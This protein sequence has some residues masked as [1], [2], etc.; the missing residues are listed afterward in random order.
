MNIAQNLW[1]LLILPILA[2]L[3]TL[4]PS[5]YMSLPKKQITLGLSLLASGVSLIITLFN[6]N[7]LMNNPGEF[8]ETNIM[9]LDAS[10]F[11]IHIGALLDNV[12]VFMLT[13]LYLITIPVQ[14]FSFKYMEQPAEGNETAFSRY[15]ILLNLFI[16][17]MAGLILSTNL[18]QTYIFWELVGLFSYLL[19]GFYYK[20]PEAEQAARKTFLINKIG[21]FALFAA[22][23]G[24]TCFLVQDAETVLYPLLSLN[25]V[26][27]WGLMAYVQLG[28]YMYAALCILIIIAGFT[29][30]AQVPF[31][32]W[33]ADAMEGPAPV[34][35]LIHGAT[36]VSAGAYLLIRLYPALILSPI[37]L[38]IIA[39][40][41]ILT[42]IMCA[43]VAFVQNDIKKILAFSTSSQLGLVFA[44]LGC[45]AYSGAILQL[46]MHGI[47][48]AMMFLVA[49]II[50]HKGMSK[51]IKF[52]GGL[53][54]HTPYLAAF[55][56]LG[57]LSLSGV[58]FSGFYAKEMILS[59][60]Y[61][62]GQFA[63]LSFIII[64]GFLSILYLFRSYFV[65]FE[66]TYKG[67]YDFS[68]DK[69]KSYDGINIYL[70]APAG[71]LAFLTAF[72]GGS[73]AP[74]FQR[75]VY[76]MRQKL[77]LTRHPELEISIFIAS[78]LIIYFMWQI[79]G[80]KRFK[81][82]KIRFIY[83]FIVLQFYINKMFD[84]IYKTLIKGVAKI[85]KTIDKYIINGFWNFTGQ[86]ARFGGYL[87]SRL[88]NGNINS[89]I[90]YS[91]L[92]LTSVLLCAAM[93]YIKRL[94]HYGG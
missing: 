18:I 71:V 8:F 67:R 47:A 40:I 77:Y 64:A 59:H 20:K 31:Q 17:S 86:I 14:V 60:L 57:T 89:Y 41:G 6:A 45:G 9:F 48:K 58:F 46:G 91:F 88:Q 34:S 5:K 56:L 83:R 87:V 1:F 69:N 19:I 65:I 13:I 53:R 4:V 32:V 22:I 29:K 52:L 94:S 66:G 33:L 16:F 70:F 28:P 49:G 38:K 7:Y 75:Y 36:M 84:F 93:V 42:A 25:D 54:E 76:I 63:S 23:L 90:F 12:S 26:S 30:S 85:I 21:D 61:T 43:V 37:A 79:Y 35:A 10:V 2:A 81:F 51:N 15:F 50:I 72:F 3:C 24:F 74:D 92:F 82:K 68:K 55:W 62:S 39:A 78:G 27:S 73:I 11:K 80:T 44:A